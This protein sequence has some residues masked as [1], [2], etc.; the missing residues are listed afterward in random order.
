MT[1]KLSDRELIIKSYTVLC[2]K[3]LNLFFSYSNDQKSNKITEQENP[4]WRPDEKIKR[5]NS[6][7]SFTYLLF[8]LTD[9]GDNVQKCTRVF[10]TRRW[11][12]LVVRTRRKKREENIVSTFGR[13]RLWTSL[14]R[15]PV[16]VNALFLLLISRFFLRIKSI[17]NLRHEYD[18]YHFARQ[19]FNERMK[20]LKLERYQREEF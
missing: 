16:S 5:R 3:K 10:S 11:A 9:T 13:F 7:V 2:A 20:D 4:T 18:L 14:E 6:E 12:I 8:N 17:L 15:S 1:T 19:L